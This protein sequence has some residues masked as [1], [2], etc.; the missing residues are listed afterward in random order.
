M[1]SF[2]R[3]HN[4][5]RK[6]AEYLVA[7]LKKIKMEKDADGLKAVLVRKLDAFVDDSTYFCLEKIELLC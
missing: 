4:D 6:I 3:T 1:H 5:P 2:F 7:A